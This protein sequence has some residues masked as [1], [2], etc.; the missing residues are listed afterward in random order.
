MHRA[1]SAAADAAADDLDVQFI[2]PNAAELT[3]RALHP[4]ETHSSLER[5]HAVFSADVDDGGGGSDGNGGAAAGV[6]AAAELDPTDPAVVEA[7][8]YIRPPLSSI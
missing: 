1:T 5:R 4:G 6:A 2:G 3:F 7:G 8:A